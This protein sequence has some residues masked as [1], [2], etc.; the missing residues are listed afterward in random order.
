[1]IIQI[2]CGWIVYTYV[3]NDPL[4][5]TDPSG[6]DGLKIKLEGAL[7]IPSTPLVI[8]VN[9]GYAAGYDN[10]GNYQ[11]GW[12]ATGGLGLGAAAS[13][14]L[15]IEAYEGSIQDSISGALEGNVNVPIPQIAPFGGSADMAGVPHGSVEAFERDQATSEGII[16]RAGDGISSI[17]PDDLN[18]N[19]NG[20]YDL[21][22]VSASV[23]IGGGA[24]LAAAN[25]LSA[26]SAPADTGP[27]NDV[28]E[29]K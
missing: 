16:D 15:G 27:Q 14:E 26:T 19:M 9:I 2:N 23:S 6:M 4:N 1:M 13:A 22:S 20:G 3:A 28:I 21:S 7:S 10:G 8:E 18:R 12:T 24:Y 25:L 5:A 17:L 29:R 11:K